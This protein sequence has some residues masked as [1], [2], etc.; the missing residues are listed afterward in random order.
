ML[1]SD[2]SASFV[3]PRAALSLR[4][5]HPHLR[6]QDGNLRALDRGVPLRFDVLTEMVALDSRSLLQ[7]IA[8]SLQ[9]V[10]EVARSL[11][12]RTEPDVERIRSRDALSVACF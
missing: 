6:F 4:R 12:G 11:V 10:V 1:C 3:R 9:R 7:G 5:R 2:I 8:D